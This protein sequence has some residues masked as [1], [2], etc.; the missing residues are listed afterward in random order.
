M[1]GIVLAT[2]LAPNLAG[3]GLAGTAVDP[4]LSGEQGGQSAAAR[5]AVNG[6]RLTARRPGQPAV[7]SAASPG[8][9]LPA[10][11][12]SGRWPAR[13]DRR[14]AASGARITLIL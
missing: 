4:V 5:R 7:T 10:R 14:P 11:L 9:P 13:I 6:V 8:A 2:M 12:R 1:N 3:S